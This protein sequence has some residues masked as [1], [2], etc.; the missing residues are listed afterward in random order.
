MAATVQKSSQKGD[1]MG[2][3]VHTNISWWQL[4]VK[5]LFCLQHLSSGA[6]VTY[7]TWELMLN[8]QEADLC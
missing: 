2:K 5:N 8:H 3:E 1:T 4:V 6:N 7:N